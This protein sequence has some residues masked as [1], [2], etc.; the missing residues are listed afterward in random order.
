MAKDR[1]T[2]R[3]LMACVVLGAFSAVLVH[4]TRLIT[5]SIQTTLP[6]LA[7]PA[8]VPYF[9]GIIMAPLLI[10]RT[11]VALLT[12][13][14][15]A[16]GGFGAMA[17]LAGIAIELVYVLGRRALSV[18]DDSPLLDRR[19]FAWS[20][21]AG[22]AGGLSLASGVLFFKEVLALPPHLL[23]TGLAIKLILGLVYGIISYYLVQALFS[24]GIN[25]QGLGV[26]HSGWVA[27]STSN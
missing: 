5:L 12:G 2:T 10:R 16:I 11:G 9:I 27:E 7:Y 26:T 15:A 24:I 25:P 13:L 23:L 6:W 18:T 14:I 8:P 19:A 17:F 1:L 21:V 3:S 4:A 20:C 22:I